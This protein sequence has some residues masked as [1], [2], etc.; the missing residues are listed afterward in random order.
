MHLITA[1]ID[2]IADATTIIQLILYEWSVFL[3]LREVGSIPTAM[4]HCVNTLNTFFIFQ[5]ISCFF[6]NISVLKI[7][8]HEVIL[9]SNECLQ[10]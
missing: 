9:S 7:C 8:G 3:G 6:L 5:L 4:N 2:S 1:C 10:V